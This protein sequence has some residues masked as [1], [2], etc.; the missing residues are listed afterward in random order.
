[1][2]LRIL[3]RGTHT[4]ILRLALLLPNLEMEASASFIDPSVR[5][6][7]R[8][9]PKGENNANSERPN[10]YRFRAEARPYFGQAARSLAAIDLYSSGAST[11]LGAGV[12]G[13]P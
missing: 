13:G 5:S 12:P 4:V 2:H 11:L 8:K 1:M 3:H 7:V 6:S 10:T 9:K